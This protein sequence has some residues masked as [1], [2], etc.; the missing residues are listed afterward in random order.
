MYLRKNLMKSAYAELNKLKMS[1]KNRYEV[2][3]TIKS[4]KHKIKKENDKNKIKYY[5]Y[6]LYLINLN[7]YEIV[8]KL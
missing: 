8:S 3:S 6:L 4:L 7:Y 5:D 1:W 2:N